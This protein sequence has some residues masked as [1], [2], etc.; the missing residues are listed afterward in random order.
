M[1]KEFDDMK[2]EIKNSSDKYKVKLYIKQCDLIVGSEEKI[3]KVKIQ[4]L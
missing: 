1:P 2:E 4:K 3:Q